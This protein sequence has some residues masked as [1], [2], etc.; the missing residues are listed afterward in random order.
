MPE[1]KPKGINAKIAAIL[2]S[3]G[4]EKPAGHNKHFSYDYWSSEQVTGL[5]RS[6]F[7]EHGLT[8]MA[9]VIDYDVKEGKTS[10]G[11]HT[12]LTTVRVYFLVTDVETGEK[13]GGHGIGQ[14]DDP[15]D[16]GSNKAMSGALKYW[17]LKT[18]L[19][20]GEDAEADERTD[21]RYDDDVRGHGGD[22]DARSRGRSR[23]GYDDDPYD[24]SSGQSRD[25]SR[26]GRVEVQAVDPPIEG[27][28]RGGRSTQAT[29]IQVARVRDLAGKLEMGI[30]GVSGILDQVLGREPDLRNA[31]EPRTELRR[32]LE[33]LS[34]DDIGNVIRY[35]EAM[36]ELK[37]DGAR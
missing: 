2:G 29:E 7:T 11:G 18:F 20:G 35:L 17:L 12:W 19:M 10:K 28:E 30:N 26:D 32:F 3:L 36:T 27:I 4:E 23:G 37:D 13:T 14:G 5:F 33:G 16:K 34:A 1:I 8:L 21:K 22:Y 24:T 9:D 6:R 15:G 25:T 31:E